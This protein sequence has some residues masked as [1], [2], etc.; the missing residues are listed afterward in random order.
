VGQA[1]ELGGAPFG[2]WFFKGGEWDRLLN[3]VPHSLEF[4]FPKGAVF[5]FAFS[6]LSTQAQ[7]ARRF[8]KLSTLAFQLMTYN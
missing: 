2:V 1:F 5:D 6:L 3:W 7:R 4:G 8:F